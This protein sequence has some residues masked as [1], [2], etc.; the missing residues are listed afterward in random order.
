MKLPDDLDRPFPPSLPLPPTYLH[1]LLPSLAACSLIN[2]HS[3]ASGVISPRLKYTRIRVCLLKA[4]TE[5][6][7]WARRGEEGQES[8]EGMMRYTTV[9]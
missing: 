6:T 9:L 2:S 3:E 8:D 5:G 4:D 7:R 1:T